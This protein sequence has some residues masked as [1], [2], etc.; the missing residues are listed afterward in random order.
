MN[1]QVEIIVG[2][3]E[4][5]YTV[6]G[7]ISAKV[8]ASTAFSKTPTM[9]DVNYKLQESALKR[10]ANAVI[11]VTYSRGIS[12][13]SWKAMFAKGIA[14]VMESENIKCPVCAELIKREAI[15]CRFCGADLAS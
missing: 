9:E 3:P 14:V 12:A 10:G 1:N 6:I 7:E 15:K 11:D 4:R 2:I 8:G 13:T 5:P